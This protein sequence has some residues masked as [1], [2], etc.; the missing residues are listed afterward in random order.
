MTKK[1]IYERIVELTGEITQTGYTTKVF[2]VVKDDDAEAV[3]VVINAFPS[4][5]IYAIFALS[6]STPNFL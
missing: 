6:P 3:Q 5:P 2:N 4:P 1:E